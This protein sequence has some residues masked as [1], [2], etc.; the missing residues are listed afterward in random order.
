VY[1]ATAWS[2]R[3]DL[4]DDPESAGL[5]RDFVRVH[6]ARHGF[7]GLVEDLSLV[8][9]ELATNAILHAQTTFSVT[10]QG[11]NESVML[12]VRDGS[13]VTPIAL[14]AQ[15]INMG[16]GGRGLAI[17]AALSDRWG[18]TP[19]SDGGKSVWASFGKRLSPERLPVATPRGH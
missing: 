10:L 16:L 12:I 19:I 14:V 11:N 7:P 6:L 18:T 3:S 15:P 8:T 9:S 2:H 13:A 1:Q 4:P 17:V 5:A